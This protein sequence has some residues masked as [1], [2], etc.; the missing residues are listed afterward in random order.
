MVIQFVALAVG[1]LGIGHSQRKAKLGSAETALALLLGSSGSCH[2]RA[3]DPGP[4]S[5]G[6][7]L[8]CLTT[9][10]ESGSPSRQERAAVSFFACELGRG[11]SHK[12]SLQEYRGPQADAPSRLAERRP[13]PD[14]PFHSPESSDD[15]N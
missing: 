13:L 12:T 5:R 9:A 14:G 10:C 6:G 8:L 11:I 15:R 2:A 4:G 3:Q 1:H 7:Q